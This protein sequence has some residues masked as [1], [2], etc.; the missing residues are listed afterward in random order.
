MNTIFVHESFRN[1]AQLQTLDRGYS[2]SLASLLFSCLNLASFCAKL[3]G[4]HLGD[5]FDRFH[6]GSATSALAGVGTIF[7][8]IGGGL[9][10]DNIPILTR[11]PIALVIF[12]IL[13]GFGYGATFNCL[14][15]LVPLV[16]GKKN[17]G[18]IQST[19]FG[20]GLVG[21][22]AGSIMTGVLRSRFG[23]YDRPFLV[24]GASCLVNFLV[25]NVTRLSLGW[26]I[27]GLKHLSA[28]TE[29]VIAQDALAEMQGEDA[30]M[31]R[32]IS[33]TDVVSMRNYS[34]SNLGKSYESGFFGAVFKSSPSVEQFLYESGSPRPNCHAIPVP[35]SDG[36]LDL[37]SSLLAL[38]PDISVHSHGGTPSADAHMQGVEFE[39]G[40]PFARD[41][42][43]Q[44]LVRLSQGRRRRR[45]QDT[46]EEHL[47]ESPSSRR[48]FRTSSTL[49]N[50]IDSGILSSSLEDIGYVGNMPSRAM[51]SPSVERMQQYPSPPGADNRA[52]TLSSAGCSQGFMQTHRYS[53][54][55]SDSLSQI[56]GLRE[57]PPARSSSPSHID[58]EYSN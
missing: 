36:V 57:S 42:S 3:V 9:S 53:R 17:L 38:S 58:G 4:G 25:F 39:S 28:E 29:P 31:Q 32:A 50:L 27:T 22:A 2:L 15:V 5:R 13:F 40:F 1:F 8:F 20:L 41:W 56:L 52:A 55:R 16:F 26:S 46:E 54:S 6:V 34:C 51:R 24:A 43:S 35:D 47:A 33:S 21:N 37:G 10:D 7:L 49:E 14:Y 12:S 11:S 45:G 18:R 23:S 19:L 30:A 48:M 44:S